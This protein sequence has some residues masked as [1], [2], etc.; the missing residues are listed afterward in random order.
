MSIPVALLLRR[1]ANT[2]SYTA[3]LRATFGASLIQQLSGRETAGTIAVDASGHGRGGTYSA[4]GIFYNRAG[5]LLLTPNIDFEQVGSLT[6]PAGTLTSL[7]AG[8][9]F[10][11]AEFTVVIRARQIWPRD[12]AGML[13]T[14]GADANN[15]IQIL[16]T[17]FNEITIT[18]KA[19]GTSIISSAQSLPLPT[20]H[21]YIV[22]ASKSGNFSRAYL[23]GTRIVNTTYVPT[24]AGALAAAFCEIGNNNAGTAPWYG[25]FDS[26]ALA[27]RACTDG[28]AATL[29]PAISPRAGIANLVH[30]GDSLTAGT[31]MT[32]G[33]CWPEQLADLFVG[34]RKLNICNMGISGWRVTQMNTA[35]AT[36]IAPLYNAAWDYNI[37]SCFAGT[38]DL[39]AGDSAATVYNNLKT[40]WAAARVTGWKV[41]ANTII[42]GNWETGGMETERLA[43]NVLIRGDASLYEYL[44]DWAGD[45]RLQTP[46]DTTYFYGD[47]IHLINTGYGVGAA[48]AK[49]GYD[50]WLH[51][52]VVVS[53]SSLPAGITST[54]YSQT[55]AA[56]GGRMP[57]T[58]AVS[59]GVLPTGLSLNSSNGAITGTPSA[60]G[61]FAFTISA[62]DVWGAVG[63]KSLSIT[64]ALLVLS[65][66][67][68]SL[69]NGDTGTAYSQTVT[70]SGGTGPYTYSVTAGALP[71]GLSLNSSN[72]AITGTPGAA[73]TYNFTIGAVDSSGAPGPYA[74]SRAY[75]VVIALLTTL[76]VDNFT[77]ADNTLL[78]AHTPDTN[79]GGNVWAG[80]GFGT[81]QVKITTNRAVPA[82]G[83]SVN[84]DEIDVLN[85]DVTIT[86]DYIASGA[87]NP[88]SGIVFRYQDSTHYWWAGAQN[89]VW[90]IFEVATARATAAVTLAAQTYALKVVLSGN[91]ITL[92]VDGVQKC[93]FSS[94]NQ[95][96]ATKHGLRIQGAAE[97]FDNLR[98]TTP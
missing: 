60:V 77:G 84:D 11:P 62:T 33:M 55:V 52:P 20:W 27:N 14:L 44:A 35:Y 86:C 5:A 87:S 43:L 69:L 92:F 64:I 73:A 9:V 51:T 96:T 53:T 78:S 66:S 1:R 98:I 68:S 94:A 45:V 8:G 19:A 26:Y 18:F 93:T 67:P 23:D 13:L 31:G 82:T 34:V 49:P 91:T 97:K 39:A 65:L 46:T 70:A 57:Y 2:D 21:T 56:S 24:W 15:L 38:N 3:A 83:G 6:F 95:A 50:A 59:A 80:P 61:T 42:P 74:G 36:R 58:W 41:E 81:A 10:N 29:S 4:T 71:T 85:A 72:G 16:T 75:S 7:N 30:D 22:C 88:F 37:L 48:I 25:Q 90:G 17:N 40:Y 47:A 28:E 89:A 79:P 32:N 12:N 54:A 63:T 76:L